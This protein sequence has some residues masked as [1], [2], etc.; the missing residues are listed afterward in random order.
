MSV[1]WKVSS[2]PVEYPAAI[3]TMEKRVND[4]HLRKCPELVWLLEHP[5]IYTAGTSAKEEDLLEKNRFPI[6]HTGRGGQFTYHGPGQ[7]I[8][9]AM[10]DLKTR[11]NQDIKNY[12]YNLEEWIINTLQHFD[13]EG[14]R[15][16][17]RIGIWVI[18]NDQNEAKIAALGMRVRKWVT[19]HGIA[20][21]ISPNLDHFSGIVPCG[22][23]K[24]GITSFEKLG[25]STTQ[26]NIDN[27][28]QEEFQKIFK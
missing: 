6:H 9:Y 11:N 15:R 25:K 14:F 1:E 17:D 10:L 19:Y 26:K 16:K 21:N 3:E 7:R 27:A 18:D 13:I 28:L 22:I 20:I 5:P 23:K 2:S 8:A 24:Y 4:I 12:V